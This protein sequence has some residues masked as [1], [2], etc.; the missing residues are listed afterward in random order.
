ML[1]FWILF[2][3]TGQYR[4]VF[5]KVL[6]HANFISFLMPNFQMSLVDIHMLSARPYFSVRTWR[7]W[8]G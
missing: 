5:R 6:S 7:T 2:V 8:A 4:T 3:D 1:N